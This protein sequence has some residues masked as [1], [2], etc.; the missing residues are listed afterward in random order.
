MLAVIPKTKPKNFPPD[1][2]FMSVEEMMEVLDS[3]KDGLSLSLRPPPLSLSLCLARFRFRS[4]P[5]S[6]SLDMCMRV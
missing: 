3:D 4:L 5:L 6:R 1:T 2:K